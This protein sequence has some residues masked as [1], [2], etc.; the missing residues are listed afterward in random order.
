MM[1][2][3]SSFR[4]TENKNLTRKDKKAEENMKRS[5]D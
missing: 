5:L 4:N 2:P 1:S 3:E